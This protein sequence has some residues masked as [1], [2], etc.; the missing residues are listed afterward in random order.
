MSVKVVG[1][2]DASNENVVWL[3]MADWQHITLTI[4]LPASN[5]IKTHVEV[6]FNPN[7]AQVKMMPTKNCTVK[8]DYNSKWHNDKHYKSYRRAMAVM[9]LCEDNLSINER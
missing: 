7:Y 2:E 5:I 6:L 8:H 4:L 3:E 9:L 1:T